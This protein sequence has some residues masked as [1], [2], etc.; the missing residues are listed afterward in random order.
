MKLGLDGRR[1]LV[2]GSSSGLGRAIA[3]EL[4]AEG[5]RVVICSRSPERLEA[6]RAAMI[7]EVRAG[8]EAEER[9]IREGDATA[10]PGPGARLHLAVADLSTSAGREGAVEAAR[11]AFGGLD[12]LVT[13][14]GGPPSGPHDA[15][16]LATWRRAYEGLL[17]SVVELTALVLP[18]MKAQGWGRIVNVTSIS[19]K[20]PVEGLILSNTL[21]AGVTGFARTV[22]NEVASQGITVNNVLPGYTRTERL[23]ELAAAGAARSGKTEAEIFASWEAQTPAGRLGE[24]HELAALATFLCSERAAF[25]TGQSV[26][27][28]GGWVRSL[29]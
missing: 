23:G 14:T 2:C 22:A 17:E 21:R 3:T 15:H 7:R 27:V 19:V 16:D 6:A 25:I 18:G 29:T 13:N 20:Q 10:R 26:A 24:P 1:A 28:D 11:E 4:L 9:G 8:G 5:A 12:I